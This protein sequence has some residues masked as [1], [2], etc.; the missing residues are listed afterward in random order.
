VS[1]KFCGVVCDE[2]GTGCSGEYCGDNDAKLGRIN[3]FYHEILGGKYL[4]RAVLFVF[5][6]GAMGTVKTGEKA[7][8]KGQSTEHQ[9][10]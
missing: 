5:E 8:T 3:V 4:P 2:H 10:F 7:T 9:I 1:A 6:P